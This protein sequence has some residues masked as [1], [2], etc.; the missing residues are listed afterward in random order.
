M[1]KQDKVGRV[2]FSFRQMCKQTQAETQC[3]SLSFR[4]PR[5]EMRTVALR[6]SELNG[7]SSSSSSLS[8]ARCLK[9]PRPPPAR[10]GEREKSERLPCICTRPG[11]GAAAL[12]ER[13]MPDMLLHKPAASRGACADLAV[14]HPVVPVTSIV[15]LISLVRA[16]TATFFFAGW[17]DALP[18]PRRFRT[19]CP[20]CTVADGAGALGF[21]R[22]DADDPNLHDALFCAGL[23]FAA[24][25]WEEAALTAA[26]GRRL[27]VLAAEAT[28][29]GAAASSGLVK[30]TERRFLAR[31]FST[32]EEVAVACSKVPP[33]PAGFFSPSLG[34][35]GLS[36][37]RSSRPIS[38]FGPHWPRASCRRPRPCADRPCVR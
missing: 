37:T 35:S 28:R 4:V 31:F 34:P 3:S 15:S 30:G 32:A 25:R 22:P 12:C 7:S 33:P 27:V 21:Q 36:G 5:C 38:T 14:S 2:S 1:L 16:A 9:R 19:G 13:C 29:A 20:P 23:G 8:S 24:V 17:R 11:A 18:T 10:V 26:S 6:Y